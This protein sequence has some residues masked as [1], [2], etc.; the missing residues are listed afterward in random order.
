MRLRH[1]LAARWRAEVTETKTYDRPHSTV[2]WSSLMHTLG[3]ETGHLMWLCQELAS[4]QRRGPMLELARWADELG[5]SRPARRVFYEMAIP[6]GSTHYQLA[7]TRRPMSDSSM[8]NDALRQWKLSKGI[9]ENRKIAAEILH[10]HEQGKSIV[11]AA[12]DIASVGLFPGRHEE[13]LLK[14]WRLWRKWAEGFGSHYY[15]TSAPGTRHVFVVIDDAL[16][17]TPQAKPLPLATGGRP[18]GR[19]NKIEKN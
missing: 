13:A 11:E 2:L 10:L 7:V 18:T 4:P 12:A 8:T 17:F 15:L 9:A 6:R 1:D 14:R 3:A 5:V 19:A 16:P